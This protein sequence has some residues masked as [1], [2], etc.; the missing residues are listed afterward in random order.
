LTPSGFIKVEPT[1]QLPGYP[2]I[3]AGGDVIDWAEQKQ[4]GKTHAHAAVIAN[5]IL[6]LLGS[7]KSTIQYKGSPESVLVTNGKVWFLSLLTSAF[8]EHLGARS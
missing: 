7:K 5:N 4:A 8:A 1:L 2:R 6:A 3:F